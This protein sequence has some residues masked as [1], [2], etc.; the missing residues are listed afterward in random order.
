[1][2]AGRSNGGRTV[3][4]EKILDE[5]DAVRAALR[6]A[7]PG[8][9]VVVCVDDALSVYREAM[10]AAGAARGATAYGDPGEFAAPEG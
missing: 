9:L 10:A 4:A 5:M 7:H 2:R 6:R 3:R 1:V 8:D